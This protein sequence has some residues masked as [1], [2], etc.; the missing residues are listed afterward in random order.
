MK[1]GYRSKA[2]TL[3]SAMYPETPPENHHETGGIPPPTK[4]RSLG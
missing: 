3:S 1:P 2:L 4:Q